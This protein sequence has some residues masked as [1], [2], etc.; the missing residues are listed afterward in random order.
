MGS[1]FLPSFQQLLLSGNNLV[2]NERMWFFI[3]H[4]YFKIEKELKRIELKYF[5]IFN[6][7]CSSSLTL[8][9]YLPI[10][11][12][13]TN[14]FQVLDRVY[15]QIFINFVK[16]HQNND[17]NNQQPQG[18]ALQ[19]RP[20]QPPQQQPEPGNDLSSLLTILNDALY[21]S[22]HSL[23]MF[24]RIGCYNHHQETYFLSQK[25]AFIFYLQ[26]LFELGKQNY[27]NFSANQNLQWMKYQDPSLQLFSLATSNSQIIPKDC[28]RLLHQIIHIYQSNYNH[29]SNHKNPARQIPLQNFEDQLTND[30][31][32]QLSSVIQQTIRLTLDQMACGLFSTAF[33]SF[34]LDKANLKTIFSSIYLELE[35]D[36]IHHDPQEQ[37]E[38]QQHPE[39]PPLPPPKPQPQRRQSQSQERLSSSTFQQM[40]HSDDLKSFTRFYENSLYP[41][42]QELITNP[43]LSDEYELPS[44]YPNYQHGNGNGNDDDLPFMIPLKIMIQDLLM[45]KMISFYF[46][47]IYFLFQFQKQGRTIP[48]KIIDALISESSSL[49]EKIGLHFMDF[50]QQEEK[51]ESGGGGDPEELLFANYSSSFFSWQLLSFLSIFLTEIDIFSMKIQESLQSL[52]KQAVYMSFIQLNVVLLLLPLVIMLRIVIII[53]HLQYN[54]LNY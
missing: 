26:Q 19:L 51:G 45:N 49:A 16:I 37:Q 32:T 47:F 10:K 8:N 25:N 52:A 33:T 36:I 46:E 21:S 20:N 6:L 5:P 48:K 7:S 27:W 54:W 40:I 53:S 2:G 15:H 3:S 17:N 31:I 34:Y 11:S 50:Q 13:V 28:Y 24:H 29:N 14:Y 18:N 4:F 39:Q 44:Y 9:H 30:A 12:I 35:I 43:L 22:F 23:T 42:Y 38:Q 1:F 41:A